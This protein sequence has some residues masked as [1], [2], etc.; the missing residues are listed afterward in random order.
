MAR[1]ENTTA[2][3]ALSSIIST[4]NPLDEDTRRRVLSSVATFFGVPGETINPREQKMAQAAG[5]RGLGFSTNHA[6][7]PKEFLME[8]QPRTD[9]ERIASLAYYLTHYRETP[10]FKTLDL[11]KLNTEAAQPK[12]SNAGY[13]THNALNMGYLVP[14]SKGYRQ[15]SAYG[16]QF[17]RALPDREAAK[18][19]MSAA[20]NRRRSRKKQS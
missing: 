5:L 6:P 7:H 17:V 4:L 2:V 8:K 15:L 11:A 3:D 1:N 14:A 13:A 20:R 9:V 18:L 19:V 12:F 10:Q 16:E